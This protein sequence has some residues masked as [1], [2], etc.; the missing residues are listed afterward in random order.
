VCAVDM[1][2]GIKD[3]SPSPTPALSQRVGETLHGLIGGTFNVTCEPLTNQIVVDPADNS[4][5]ARLNGYVANYEVPVTHQVLL[6]S[7]IHLDSA[8]CD[9]IGAIPYNPTTSPAPVLDYQGIHGLLIGAHEQVHVD[10]V[11]NE[12]TAECTALQRTAGSLASRG[13]NLNNQKLK[14]AI[15]ER[16]KL[17]P[18]QYHSDECRVDGALDLTPSDD[19][20][21]DAWLP[22]R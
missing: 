13:Y 15:R 7:R 19:A 6:G 16:M 14:D 21:S 4:A 17:F 12:A 9:A 2:V 11:F 1:K 10:G 3:N 5:N 18:S 20:P 22:A 8:I